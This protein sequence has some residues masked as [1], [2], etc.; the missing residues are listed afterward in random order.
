MTHPVLE[1]LGLGSLLFAAAVLLVLLLRPLLRRLAGAQAQ[2]QLWLLVPAVLLAAALAAWQPQ[3][4]LRWQIELPGGDWAAPLT[5]VIEPVAAVAPAAEARSPLLPPLLLGAWLLGV[6]ACAG[7]W[8]LAQR[9]LLRTRRLAAGG[10]AALV[11]AWRPRLYL[12]ADFRSRFPAP[13][14][15]L[16]LLHERL[17]AERGDT[18]W[19]LLA[20]SLLALQWFNPLAWWALRRLRADMELACDADLLRRHPGQL[21]T[22]RQ[23]L[24]RAEGFAARLPLSATPC[25]SHPLIERLSMLPAH[26][27]RAPRRGLAALVIGLAAGLAYA[28]QPALPGVQAPQAPAE[29]RP[30]TAPSRAAYPS[31]PTNLPALQAPKTQAPPTPP[32]LRA[33]AAPNPAAAPNPPSEAP[34]PPATV[35]LLRTDLKLT[36]GGQSLEEVVLLEAFDKTSRRRFTLPNGQELE[37]ELRGL[38][39]DE[40]RFPKDSIQVNIGV[41]NLTTGKVLFKPRLVTGNG[42]EASV[43]QSVARTDGQPDLDAF[44]IDLLSR[45]LQSTQTDASTAHAS[46]LRDIEA[47]RAPAPFKR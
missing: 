46:L 24:L 8:S 47:G 34:T 40:T 15:R 44:R 11:G 3:R 27:V 29:P 33:P 26:S 41:T 13:E 31:V 20:L 18:R 28:A 23:A 22:Y 19:L 38:P 45:K 42:V 5:T 43:E 25:S 32:A 37:V 35:P 1:T 6:L 30:P 4:P 21:K 39:A 7:V 16:I 9:R 36:I 17:H 10:S 12:P 2:Y 14:R